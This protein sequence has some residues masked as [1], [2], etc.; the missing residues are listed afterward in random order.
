MPLVSKEIVNVL[1]LNNF[2]HGKLY[3]T[4]NTAN[5]TVIRTGIGP[6]LL[7]DVVLYLGETT[8]QNIILF[9]SCGLLPNVRNIPVGSN[10]TV[11]TCYALES[12]SEML[13]FPNI[14]LSGLYPDKTL[15]ESFIRFSS[16]SL[17][18]VT[19]TTLGSLKLQKQYQDLLKQLHIQVV[20]MECSAFFA[21]ANYTNR[22]A[23][24]L[25]Y[26]N[27][28]IDK[29]PFYISNSKRDK[30]HIKHGIIQGIKLLQ[31]FVNNVV[32]VC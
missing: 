17:H 29:K 25:F 30:Q 7:G 13:S 16:S 22:R 24:T 3:S 8:C 19:C 26:V 12:F 32:R 11:H 20:D 2:Y 21:A 23:L 9:G 27:D 6:A 5:F 4:G 28:I 18:E 15:Y 1:G 31:D 14:D 10:V